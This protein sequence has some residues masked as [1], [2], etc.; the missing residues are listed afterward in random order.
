MWAFVRPGGGFMSTTLQKIFAFGAALAVLFAASGAS[1]Q[2]DK[3]LGTALKKKL[4]PVVTLAP[5]ENPPLTRAGIKLDS[6]G[7]DTSQTRTQRLIVLNGCFGRNQ[8]GNLHV[9]LRRNDTPDGYSPTWAVLPNA[10]TRFEATKAS[11]IT[12]VEDW[13][14][15]EDMQVSLV[16]R[17][18]GGSFQLTDWVPVRLLGVDD[19]GDGHEP[20]GRGGDDCDDHD[21]GR[22]PGNTEVS[23]AAGHD[24]D[25]DPETVGARDADNDGYID[26]GSCNRY[27]DGTMNCGRDCDDSNSAVH[28]TQIDILNDRDDDCDKQ[29]DE[30][31]PLQLLQSILHR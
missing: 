19:D 15:S 20:Y 10:P 9:W 7:Y 28:P 25:C 2:I 4:A 16:R 24:E 29:V 12:T 8:S 17:D 31:Q 18:Q 5:C 30:D 23:D 21:A 14:E 22:Y 6:A 3:R 1:A 11:V 13:M 27:P 26:A